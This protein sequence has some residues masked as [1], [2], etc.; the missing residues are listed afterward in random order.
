MNR[1]PLV[2]RQIAVIV[3]HKFI[4]EEIDAY[5]HGFAALG[6]QVHLV[7]RLKY[8]DETPGSVTFF[9]D[10]DPLDD[11]PWQSPRSVKVT[12][13][14]SS[15]Q[16]DHYA[17]LIM[18]A[19]YT[20]VRLRWESLPKPSLVELTDVDIAAFDAHQ[21]VRSCPAVKF[22]ARAMRDKRLVKGALCH[23]LWLLTPYRELLNGR[24]VICHSVVMADVLNCGARIDLT[25]SGVVV[26]DD[27]VTGFSRHEVDAFIEAIT[28]N[29]LER[30]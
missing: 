21:Y 9:S 29:I 8:G 6:A 25:R 23:G 14:I 27:L 10:V 7:S 1:R 16:L 30:A 2:G 12:R 13:D 11:L 18:S 22:F 19:N 15:V 5:R 24:R 4:P 28:A 3:E 17:A 20:S 26:D